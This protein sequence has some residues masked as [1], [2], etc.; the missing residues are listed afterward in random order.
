MIVA[1]VSVGGVLTVGTWADAS[2]TRDD[3]V[4]QYGKFV[5]LNGAY[6]TLEA[7]GKAKVLT[8]STENG[9][10]SHVLDIAKPVNESTDERPSYKLSTSGVWLT[11][12]SKGSQYMRAYDAEGSTVGLDS[13]I[14]GL[15]FTIPA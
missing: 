15:G 11:K 3:E 12:T 10:R 9:T 7:K 4:V 2:F 1:I 8:I 13:T 5:P 6:A 14:A